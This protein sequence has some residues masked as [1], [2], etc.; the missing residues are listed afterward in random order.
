MTPLYLFI[1]LSL[2]PMIPRADLTL[3]TIADYASFLAE[4]QSTPEDAQYMNRVY[5]LL[6]NA[7]TGA[8]I[9]IDKITAPANIPK[10]IR[11]VCLYICDTNRAEFD[12]E[13]KFIKKL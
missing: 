12:L 13:Y 8:R 2:Y 4:M 1:H 10:F 7:K 11:C 3:Q 5:S 9:E 6:S